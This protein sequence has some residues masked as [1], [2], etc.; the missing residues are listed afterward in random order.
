MSSP[1]APG[2]GSAAPAA[3]AKGGASP[4][5]PAATPSSAPSSSTTSQAPSDRQIRPIP[6]PDHQ[7]AVERRRAAKAAEK[8]GTPAKQNDA[9][10]PEPKPAS[11]GEPTRDP[12]T[13]RF[14]PVE[15][16]AEVLR[17]EKSALEARRERLAAKKAAPAPPAAGEQPGEV[18]DPTKAAKPASDPSKPGEPVHIPDGPMQDGRFAL[19][20]KIYPNASA[21]G[22]AHRSLQGIH[23]SLETTTSKAAELARGWEAAH[24][25]DV[26]TLR[27]HIAT[28]QNE[29]AQLKGGVQSPTSGAQPAAA[30]QPTPAAQ[31][32]SKPF[33]E[34]MDWKT[35]NELYRSPEF[36]P[37]GAQ[38]FL[39]EN[40]NNHIGSL[41]DSLKAE[42]LESMKS[43]L[44][45]LR[46]THQMVD[47]RVQSTAALQSARALW[48]RVANATNPESG[49]PYYPELAADPKLIEEILPIWLSY[50]PQF[51]M[52]DRGIFNAYLEWKHWRGTAQAQ[53]TDAGQTAAQVVAALDSQA[54]AG[55]RAVVAGASTHGVSPTPPA[56]G[57]PRANRGR[58]I[59]D[60]IKGASSSF[61]TSTGFD[62]GRM[63]R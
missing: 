47:Q 25:R 52:T 5:A 42:I 55:A 58:A 6:N 59:M 10:T 48:S 23:K 19:G 62:L 56:P 28:L 31:A 60:G 22:Q 11:S 44:E 43:E 27:S 50:G 61:K 54:N 13:G 38:I 57:D 40:L 9:G 46:K 26:T 14:V 29:L 39:M 2:S 21:A 34:S 37:V 16:S 18:P 4:A 12:S 35:F 51:G 45:P 33:Q 7:S 17:G 8:S 30:S 1:A 32:A 49:E 24:T 3:P 20:N 63:N 36:G 53:Q 15:S 41:R